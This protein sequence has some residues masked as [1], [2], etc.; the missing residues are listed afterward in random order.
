MM[1]MTKLL[2][3]RGVAIRVSWP[4][5]VLREPQPDSVVTCT[6]A[7]DGAHEQSTTRRAL[8]LERLNLA[9]QQEQH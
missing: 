3:T 9:T 7:T 8:G 2:H 4:D 5:W 6:V 1:A